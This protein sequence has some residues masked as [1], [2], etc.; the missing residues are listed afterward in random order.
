[1]SNMPAGTGPP[2]VSD[3]PDTG[4]LKEDQEVIQKE[5][6]AVSVF[7]SDEGKKNSQPCS[8]MVC[9]YQQH[10]EP[11]PYQCKLFGCFFAT[12]EGSKIASHYKDH[13]L[14]VDS[15]TWHCK[16][17]DCKFT[18][19]RF[20]DLMRHSTVKHCKTV[21]KFPCPVPYCKYSGDNGFARK[22]KLRSHQKNVHSELKL[23]SK[24]PKPVAS[25]DVR[26]IQPGPFEN[27]E[28]NLGAITSGES[29]LAPRSE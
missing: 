24:G 26:A 10:W 17:W 7:S 16:E 11:P 20:T 18:T 5:Q 6:F 23:H 3:D 9:L 8:C 27:Q 2:K 25:Q 22:D 29:K 1:M 13:Y 15:S 28:Q 19:K 14:E 4:L 12:A 21:T